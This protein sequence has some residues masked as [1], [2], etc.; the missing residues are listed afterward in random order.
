MPGGALSENVMRSSTQ[1]DRHLG[2]G[3]L[4]DRE[5]LFHQ[6]AVERARVGIGQHL[7]DRLAHH[8]VH[9][10]HRRQEDELLPALAVHVVLRLD[11]DVGGLGGLDE[12]R[13]P[14]VGFA[15]HA[16]DPHRRELRGVPHHAGPAEHGR[17]IGG[18]GAGRV[19]A[20]D[21]RDALVA[22]DAVLQGDD[23]GVRADQRLGQ[24]GRGLGVPQLDRE[25]HDIDR[26]DLL[27]IGRGVDLR[28]VQVAVHAFDLQPVLAQRV[29]VGA[30][31]DVGDVM[32]RGLHP[33]AE[34]G[35]DR[36]GRHR[37]DFHVA[38]LRILIDMILSD[39]IML[40]RTRSSE[41]KGARSSASPLPYSTHSADYCCDQYNRDADEP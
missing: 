39:R 41:K 15:V 2:A 29:E 34:I 31:R 37:C 17:D 21:R 18:A 6:L 25:Q 4:A 9:A 38:S 33:P 13:E 26:A 10:G 23:A 30:A 22:V 24:L 27:R 11:V 12:R 5:A 36:A 1:L 19:L 40:A 32:A 3:L 7:A 28:Q 16:A 35:A 20:E 8:A 14:G